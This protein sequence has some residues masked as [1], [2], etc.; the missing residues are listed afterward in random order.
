MSERLDVRQIAKGR[1]RGI[2]LALGLDERTLSGKHCACPLCGGKDRFRFDDKDGRGTYFCSGCR[3]GDGV[4][5]AMGITD[6][7]FVETARRIEQLAG[8]VQPVTRTPERSDDDKL[9]ALRRVFRESAPIQCGDEAHRYLAGRGL[10]L[11]DL[12]ESIRLHPALHYRDDETSGMFPAMVSLVTGPD[13]KARSLHRTYLHDARKAPV[14]APKKLMQG[15]PLAGAA[16]R[17]TPVSEVLGIAE[18]IETA[19][20]A[21]ELF[22]V[23]TWSCIST[24]GI[25][26]FEPPEGVREIVIFADHDANFAGQ[27]AAYAAAHRL[28]LKGFEVEVC[29]P[30]TV[31]DWLD[32]LNRRKQKI[33]S[34]SRQA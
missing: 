12:P 8:V 3:P 18:G 23:P 10:A 14:A 6:L 32:D 17:L 29:I 16:I 25:E 28:S 20:A 13:G 26:S 22:E 4:Q 19:L 2:L 24:A 9:D 27:K 31:G 5:L 33:Q 34:G 30:P 21:S 1:W 11:Y 15:L 7:S